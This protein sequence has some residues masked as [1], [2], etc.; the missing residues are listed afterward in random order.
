MNENETKSIEKILEEYKDTALN[1]SQPALFEI[2][3]L[4]VQYP[5]DAEFGSRVRELLNRA[6]DH[7]KKMVKEVNDIAL[8]EMLNKNFTDK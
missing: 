6:E 5:N 2:L 8:K 3:K 1:F 4:S 7:H